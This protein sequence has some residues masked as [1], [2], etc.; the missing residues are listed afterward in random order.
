[1]LLIYYFHVKYAVRKLMIFV[2]TGQVKGTFIISKFWYIHRAVTYITVLLI[3]V[4]IVFI[5]IYIYRIVRI[6][7]S[8][9]HSDQFQI[10]ILRIF[11][12][13]KI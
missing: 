5:Y 7:D 4:F 12:I 11:D 8:I 9:A 13:Q 6:G 2:I 3:H 10:T 1:M